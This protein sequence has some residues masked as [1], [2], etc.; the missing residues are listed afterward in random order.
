MPAADAAVT[1]KSV[2]TGDAMNNP[3]GQSKKA[4]ETPSLTKVSLQPEDAVL[5]FCKNSF[6][7]GPIASGCKPL[8][9]NCKNIGS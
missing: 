7:T 9:V 6:H 2:N 5:G 3:I 8:G 4:Y 1:R